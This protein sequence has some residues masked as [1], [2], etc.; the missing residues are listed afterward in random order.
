MNKKWNPNLQYSYSK[1]FK[2]CSREIEEK[3]TNALAKLSGFISVTVT[4]FFQGSTGVE[5]NVVT[6]AG[7]NVTDIS[8]EESIKMANSSGTLGLTVSEISVE[9]EDKTT[10][11]GDDGLETWVIV[12]IVASIIVFL[13]V[14]VIVIL[15]VSVKVQRN[16]LSL[17]I[18]ESSDFI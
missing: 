8:I 11:G 4:R 14:I 5:M 18:L 12:I 6:K 15:A 7:S 1:D 17:V 2:T 13:M 16:S 10:N 3:V 9:K